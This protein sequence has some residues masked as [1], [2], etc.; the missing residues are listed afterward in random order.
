MCSGYQLNQ[1]SVQLLRTLVTRTMAAKYGT[2]G[3]SNLS[4]K[5]WR[6]YTESLQQ[7]FKANDVTEDKQKAIL[8]SGCGVAT[9]RL[10]KN[11]TV[12]DKPTDRLFAELVDRSPLQPHPFSIV[13]CF[14]FN[15]HIR[16]PGESVP[17]FICDWI[18]K[19]PEQSR[20]N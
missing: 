4:F 10:T 15:I 12:P 17:T 14:H 2:F 20:K 9:Y 16:Q 19:N 7:Y 1:P 13:E 18:C 8:L 3:K 11:L 6:S 5:D